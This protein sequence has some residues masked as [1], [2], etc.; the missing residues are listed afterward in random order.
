MSA[1]FLEVIMERI[2]GVLRLGLCTEQQVS[3]NTENGL[4]IQ[5]TVALYKI[6]LD[7][8]KWET[9]PVSMFN[10]VLKCIEIVVLLVL[11]LKAENEIH[12]DLNK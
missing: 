12:K 11:S 5:K 2:R 10:I 7:Y 6:T 8:S 1:L 9:N 3:I 4:N